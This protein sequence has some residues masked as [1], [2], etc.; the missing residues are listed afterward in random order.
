MMPHGSRARLPANDRLV[1]EVVRALEMGVRAS[2]ADIFTRAKHLKHKLGYSTIYR[3]LDRLCDRGLVL[4][5]HVPEQGA[6]LFRA[7][8][9][10]PCAFRL[11]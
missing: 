7:S 11:R 9:R 10:D 2:V 5:L 1:H 4:E 6:A 8:A 3:A